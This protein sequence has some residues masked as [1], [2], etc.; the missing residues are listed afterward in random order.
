MRVSPDA[1]HLAISAPAC[2]P[3]CMFF[4]T[5]TGPVSGVTRSVFLRPFRAPVLRFHPGFRF[6]PPW[7]TILRR[8][9][10]QKAPDSKLDALCDRY[11]G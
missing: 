1:R 5:E 8:F 10:S 2:L 6:A 9:A 7:A 11:W 3:M 4:S